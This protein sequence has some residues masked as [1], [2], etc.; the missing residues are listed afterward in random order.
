MIR[1]AVLSVEDVPARSPNKPGQFNR[2]NRA[3]KNR[4]HIRV[5]GFTRY[6]NLGLRR[7]NLGVT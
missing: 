2:V 6:V 1:G 4:F 3:V 7:L 5:K